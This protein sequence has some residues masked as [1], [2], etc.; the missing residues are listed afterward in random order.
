MSASYT[1][2]RLMGGGGLISVMYNEVE[3]NEFNC[4]TN[5]TKIE[6]LGPLLNP[7]LA[8]G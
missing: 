2:A 7:A 5:G 1:A 4:P 8:L 3:F 6:A